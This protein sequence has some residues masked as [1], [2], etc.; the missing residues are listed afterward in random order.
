MNTFKCIAVKNITTTYH[1]CNNKNKVKKS[2]FLKKK[3]KLLYELLTGSPN[4]ASLST[5]QITSED[6]G[7]LDDRIYTDMVEKPELN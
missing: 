2:S 7:D 6:D 4:K 1:H 5:Q 3:Q